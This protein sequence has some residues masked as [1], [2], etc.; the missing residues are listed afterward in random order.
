[1]QIKIAFILNILLLLS[2]FFMFGI[3]GLPASAIG[4]FFVIL[5]IIVP[6]I[7][8][9]NLLKVRNES[10]K[11]KKSERR[12]LI[13]SNILLLVFSMLGIVI[14]GFTQSLEMLLYIFV[15]IFTPIVNLSLLNY[16]EKLIEY[17]LHYKKPIALFIVKAKRIIIINKIL[18]AFV[19]FAIVF[20]YFW[21][22]RPMQIRK[23]CSVV[24]KYST[25]LGSYTVD[26][27]DEEYRSCLRKNGMEVT[28]PLSQ[29]LKDNKAYCYKWYGKACDDPN[30]NPE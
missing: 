10:F 21:G 17:F 12:I 28:K 9:H 3:Y 16:W 20:V 26:A 29:E 27:S 22:I 4:T 15:L 13:I 23:Q 5:I 14:G 6:I 30:F 2:S 1:M 11:L 8:L 24:V 25:W 18:I 19:L 7:N